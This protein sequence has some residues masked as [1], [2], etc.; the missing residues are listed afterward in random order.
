MPGATE[1]APMVNVTLTCPEGKVISLGEVVSSVNRYGHCINALGDC[2]DTTDV[3][4]PCQRQRECTVTLNRTYSPIC[5]A[6]AT[7]LKVYYVCEIAPFTTTTVPSVTA[8]ST[9][10]SVT[11]PRMTEPA[12]VAN[13]RTQYEQAGPGPTQEDNT[14]LIAGCVV[15]VVITV[16]LLIIAIIMVVRRLA[17]APAVP[18]AEEGKVAGCEILPCVAATEDEKDPK[19]QPAAD[20]KTRNVSSRGWKW[21]NRQADKNQNMSARLAP[22]GQ[23]DEGTDSITSKGPLVA[24]HKSRLDFNKETIEYP[25]PSRP[26]SSAREE[27][28]TLGVDGR[29]SHEQRPGEAWKR[30]SGGVK[31]KSR[32]M[33]CAVDVDDVIS[34]LNIPSAQS[35]SSCRSTRNAHTVKSGPR[36]TSHQFDAVA[37][38]NTESSTSC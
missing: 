10:V 35:A 17:C 36:Q 1:D 23:E 18:E 31:R 13:R 11:S 34:S 29:A 25:V 16:I 15:A 3:F 27:G 7:Q 26:S 22:V 14:G 30:M 28:A 8:T 21:R 12:T 24:D 38:P 6:Y 32:E 20:S 4:N 37:V 9:L 33:A 2:T 5:T 19:H